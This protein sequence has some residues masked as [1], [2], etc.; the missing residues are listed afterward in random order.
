MKAEDTSQKSGHTAPPQSVPLSTLPRTQSAPIANQEAFHLKLFGPALP[1][2]SYT[3]VNPYSSFP[4]PVSTNQPYSSSA[5][6]VPP[7]HLVIPYRNLLQSVNEFALACQQH[8]ED[9]RT[10]SEM[11]SGARQMRIPLN[12]APASASSR[13]S[14]APPS[15]RERPPPPSKRPHS[16]PNPL[17]AA[18]DQH[19]SPS[20]SLPPHRREIYPQPEE[21]EEL[22]TPQ[23][24][25]SGYPGRTATLA[26]IK[27]T[28]A[29][30]LLPPM[31]AGEK[32]ENV[33]ID[34]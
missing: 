19:P 24:L 15:I 25:N 2:M 14:Q 27:A 16:R 33:V 8:A 13:N 21:T 3:P 23:E 6:F 9:L 26:E 4:M 31:T 34:G 22:P 5:D 7:P 28:K 20:P 30:Q 11:E 18:F 10:L 17:P 1:D 32:N 29:H 12:L